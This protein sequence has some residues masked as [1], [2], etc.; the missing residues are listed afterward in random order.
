M[1]LQWTAPSN[2]VT[3]VVV[4]YFDSLPMANSLCV[5][6]TGFLF[7]ASDAASH[8]LYQFQGIGDEGKGECY[9]VE[10]DENT[11]ITYGVFLL[12]PG[13]VDLWVSI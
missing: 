6:K 12:E 10:G 7:L 3:A 2:A 8:V 9:T 5:L 1:T 13:L 11:Y 4:S